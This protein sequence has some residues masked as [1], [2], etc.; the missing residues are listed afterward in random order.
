MAVGEIGQDSDFKTEFGSIKL[1]GVQ[2]QKVPTDNVDENRN[3][4]QRQ[5][6]QEPR[7]NR[8]QVSVS[9]NGG[10]GG[11]AIQLSNCNVQQ[12]LIQVNDKS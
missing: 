6:D 11:L 1:V 7:E 8:R 10:A 5:D 12:I 3:V 9:N 2:A 4:D